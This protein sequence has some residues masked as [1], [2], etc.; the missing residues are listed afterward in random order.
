[1]LANMKATDI[2]KWILVVLWAIA[3]VSIWIGGRK[4][5]AL[6]LL[7]TIASLIIAIRERTK[8]KTTV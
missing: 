1:M 8:H 2:A 6:A 3:I 5:N 7:L 4:Y